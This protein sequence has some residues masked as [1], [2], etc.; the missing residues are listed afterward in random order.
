ME[1]RTI[2]IPL[3]GSHLAESA[4]PY[5]EA[6]AAPSHSRLVLLR[7]V[8]AFPY[9]AAVDERSLAEDAEQYLERLAVALPGRVG[10][11]VLI[12]D[13]AAVIAREAWQRQADLVIMA[14]RAHARPGGCL[15]GSVAE[16]LL[17]RSRVPLLLVRAGHA[18]ARATALTAHPCVIVLLDGSPLAE[19]ALPVAAGLAQTLRGELL[20]VG[21][22]PPPEPLPYAV[23]GSG[24]NV[25][26]RLRSRVRTYLRQVAES[27]VR[28]YGLP[29]PRVEVRTGRTAVVLAEAIHAHKASL[30]VM[31]T[32]GHLRRRQVP[33]A[34]P[35]DL[36]GCSEAVPLILV[37]RH[38]VNFAPVDI[39]PTLPHSVGPGSDGPFG[40]SG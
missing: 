11:T 22:T 29:C 9:S 7:A 33:L 14:M 2:L 30:V 26:D 6:L 38:V 34:N 39:L 27:V 32:H 15:D 4:L 16:Q 3:D 1:L 17:A 18:R 25:T 31:S 21:S 12:G 8:P 28:T 23:I 40:T 5:A 10:I 37:R 19:A 36:L 13:T 24:F 20:L 35:A